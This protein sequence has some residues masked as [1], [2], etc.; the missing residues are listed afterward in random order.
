MVMDCG[1]SELL[2]SDFLR[3]LYLVVKESQMEVT[4]GP[5]QFL[6]AVPLKSYAY[7]RG[8]PWLVGRYLHPPLLPYRITC[9]LLSSRASSRVELEI[10][11]QRCSRLS[12]CDGTRHR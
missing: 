1:K 9:H 6:T 2:S 7:I 10:V 5:S 11:P 8:S 3:Y 4:G 12:P